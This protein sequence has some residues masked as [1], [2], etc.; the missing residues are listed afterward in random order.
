MIALPNV[1]NYRL[2]FLLRRAINLVQTLFTDHRHV[3]RHDDRF[4]AID[5]LEFVGFGIRCACHAGQLAVHP[6]IILVRNRGQRLILALY[7][8]ALLRL[9]C[10]VQSVGPA[11]SG[12]QAASKFIDN[13]NFVVLRHIVLVA[14]KQ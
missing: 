13:D 12:R 7:A 4:E 11:A 9:D 5:L 14:M 10:L 6:K 3:R 2:I 8:Y 1:I